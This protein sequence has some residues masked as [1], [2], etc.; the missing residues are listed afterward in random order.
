M[1]GDMS[2]F[3]RQSRIE[4]LETRRLLS[5]LTSAGDEPAQ[6]AAALGFDASKI[7]VSKDA[8]VVAA[9]QSSS[10]TTTTAATVSATLDTIVFGNTSSESSHGFS[11]NSSQIIAGA[12]GQSARQLLPLS[13]L[14]VNGGDMTFTM[15]V[16]P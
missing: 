4:L 16:D 9:P 13:P 12:L 10:V 3:V 1:A 6:L 8:D 2:G 14:A 7:D 5:G 15:S 11:Q